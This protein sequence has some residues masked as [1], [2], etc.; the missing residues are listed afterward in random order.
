[1]SQ[2][3][4]V[5]VV[6]AGPGG[7]VAANTLAHH[8][9][10]VKLVTRDRFSHFQPGNLFIA[11][12]GEPPDA[13]LR[14]VDSLVVRGVSVVYDTVTRVDL[15]ERL[16]ETASGRRLEYSHLVVAAGARLDWQAIPGVGEAR[17]RWG[18]Y[19]STPESAAKLW[20]TLRGLREGTFLI[21]VADPVY[22]CVPG[23]HKGAFL[24]NRALRMLGSRARVVL[25]VP[26]PHVYPS[27]VISGV[28]EE[29]MRAEGIEWVTSF[30]LDSI[31]PEGGKAVS[32]EG[33]EIEFTAATVIPP[34][35]GPG[36]EAS[37]AE[38]LDEDGYFRVDKYTLQIAG[39]DDAYA[40]GD[41]SNAPTSKTGV[42]AHLGGEVAAR[43]IMGFDARFDGRTNCPLLVD[44]EALFVI[45]DYDHPPVPARFSRFKRLLEDA[46]IAAYWSSL[47]Y[48]WRWSGIFEAYFKASSP[49]ALG[50][51][52]W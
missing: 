39:Y 7:L 28:V 1:M 9:F 14:S 13:Y 40:V 6:G 15:G 25:A 45:S 35:V 30:T 12:Q 34:H 4:P 37:P 50:D 21:A 51:R 47:K 3:K 8:G 41:C 19:Y 29:R 27:A 11:F 22:K 23:P 52:G 32:L 49:E 16:V 31:D 2:G 46:F 33:E 48:P 5:V 24:S 18:D 36:I 38:A 17:E 10:D 44:G 43:R 42:T 26:F 20:G